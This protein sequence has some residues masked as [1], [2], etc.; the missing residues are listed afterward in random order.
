MTSSRQK[1]G[2]S[3]WI[4]RVLLKVPG[5]VKVI[6]SFEIFLFRIISCGARNLDIN[7]LGH[8]RLWCMVPPGCAFV[9]HSRL[10]NCRR[11]NFVCL[12]GFDFF[13]QF[14][15]PLT[16]SILANYCWPVINDLLSQDPLLPKS[17]ECEGE[18][19]TQGTWSKHKTTALKAADKEELLPY[20]Y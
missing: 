11:F 7:Y 4:L 5:T 18:I 14:F 1:S 13:F 12:L 10:I 8:D 20:F 15:F 3:K 9:V 16:K 19:Y 2:V 17:E 6:Y